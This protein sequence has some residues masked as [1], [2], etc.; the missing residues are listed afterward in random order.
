MLKEKFDFKVISH[1]DVQTGSGSD[2]IM[3]TGSGSD[4]NTRIWLDPD[5]QHWLRRVGQYYQCKCDVLCVQEKVK[6]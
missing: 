3:E 5:P 4:Q 6:L 1:L 2:E